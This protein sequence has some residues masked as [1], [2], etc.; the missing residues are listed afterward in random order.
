MK[1]FIFFAILILGFFSAITAAVRPD[2]VVQKY[3]EVREP[4]TRYFAEKH[5]LT[6]KEAKD[7]ERA[8]WMLKRQ[9]PADCQVPKTALREMECKNKR[10]LYSQAFEQNWTEKIRSGWKPEGIEE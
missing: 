2:I 3:T 8:L 7:S 9:L 6:W 1:L 5:A 10:D 4:L